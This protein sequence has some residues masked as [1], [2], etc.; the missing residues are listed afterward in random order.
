MQM[1]AAPPSCFKTRNRA[2][3]ASRLGHAGASLPRVGC[4][5]PVVATGVGAACLCCLLR[6]PA[7]RAVPASGGPFVRADLGAGQVV[8]GR[9]EASATRRGVPVLCHPMLR[10]RRRAATCNSRVSR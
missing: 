8:G 6:R 10:C 5:G 7:P 4:C 3:P 2:R 9:G 1:H